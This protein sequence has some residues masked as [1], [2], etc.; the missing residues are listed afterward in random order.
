MRRRKLGVISFVRLFLLLT[1]L[2]TISLN[3]HFYSAKNILKSDELE[4]NRVIAHT[5]SSTTALP[6]WMQDYF[7]WHAL[8]SPDDSSV[9]YLVVRCLHQDTHCGGTADRLMPLPLFVMMAARMKRVLLFHWER[10]CPLEEYLVPS[11]D[12]DWRI[13]KNHDLFQSLDWKSTVRISHQLN[14][15]QIIDPKFEPPTRRRSKPLPTVLPRV[16]TTAYQSQLHGAD[17]Y[18]QFRNR[19]DLFQ[20]KDV[21]DG[22]TA[23]HGNEPSFEQVYSALW[24]TFFQPSPRLQSKIDAALRDMHLTPNDYVAA[25]IR[26]LYQQEA[27]P[28][29]TAF[30]ARNAMHC[31]SQFLSYKG[32]PIYVVSDSVNST[33]MAMQYVHEQHSD[34]DVVVVTR[35]VTEVLHLDR[36]TAFLKKDADQWTKNGYCADYDD[37][38]VDLYLLILAKCRTVHLGSFAKWAHLIHGGNCI[39]SHFQKQCRWNKVF[40][41]KL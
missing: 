31:A 21:S 12:I 35:P 15:L 23:S 39:N 1:V 10:P 16:V 13:P 19:T 20:R 26:A 17:L 11:T 6:V 22:G 14:V 9:E 3:W 5:D 37:T 28:K 2:V 27:G 29:K 32:Q 40:D 34:E 7:K 30:V 8:Q 36:G 38:F 18:D 25:H 41:S 4:R 33:Q 24:K